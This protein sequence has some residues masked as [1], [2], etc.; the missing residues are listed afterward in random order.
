MGRSADAA[1]R[2]EWSERLRRFAISDLTVAAFCSRERVSVPTF[3]LWRRRLGG[4]FRRGRDTASIG[5]NAGMRHSQAFV[6]VQITQSAVIRM[7][8]PN[9]VQLSLPAGDAALLAAAIAAAGNLSGGSREDE[10]C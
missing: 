7:R 3:Y 4:Q 8:L 9:G 10:A 2:R 1:K 5:A 6:P